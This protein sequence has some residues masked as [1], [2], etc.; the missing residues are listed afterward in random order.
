[1]SAGTHTV[2][3]VSTPDVRELD[4]RAVALSTEVVGRVRPEDLPRPTPCAE[5]ALH[6]LLR[7]MAAQHR[8]FAAAAR[9]GGGDAAHWALPEGSGTDPVAAH[10]SAAADVVAAF[11][12]ADLDTAQLTLPDVGGGTFPAAQAMSFHGIDYLMHAWDVGAS[13]GVPVRPDDDLLPA[14]LRITSAVPTGAARIAPGAAFAP[15]L[16]AAAEEKDVW[17]RILLTLGRD[18]DWR[19]PV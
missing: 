3:D 16:G 2:D 4:R 9:G 6:D 12:E 15:V 18:P 5:W 11:A 7:H 19:S 10:Q 8:G 14:A 17:R 13:I 1:V